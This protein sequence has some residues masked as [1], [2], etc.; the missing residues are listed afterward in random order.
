[1][2]CELTAGFSKG[3]RDNAGGIVEVYLANFPTGYTSNEWYTEADGTVSSI[4]GLTGE[5]Y[6]FEPNKNSSSWTENI[7]S[8]VENGTVG[9]EPII[10]LVF[11]KNEASK[12][13]AIKLLGKA[14]LIAII[15]DKNEK[16]WILGTQ[17]GLELNGGTS[18][19]GTALNDLNGWNITIGGQEP[20]PA[21]EV[22]SG[23][24]SALL[25]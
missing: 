8:S 25:A 5:M 10:T 3:C 1:M 19:S 2:A 16:Y 15:R 24:I 7:L 18:S 20:E 6:Q 21:F 17:N 9:Y 22:A 13:V 12:T 4:S 14:N 11:A 23:L